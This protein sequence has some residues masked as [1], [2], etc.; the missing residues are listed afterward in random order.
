MS[1]LEL[2]KLEVSHFRHSLEDLTP[3]HIGTSTHDD[4]HFKGCLP[5]SLNTFESDSP[6][7]PSLLLTAPGI[8]TPSSSN[9]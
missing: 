7:T 3:L 4:G 2:L 6:E 9:F 8:L 5:F 1:D